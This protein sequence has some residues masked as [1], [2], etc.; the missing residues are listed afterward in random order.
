M[1]L[2]GKLKDQLPTQYRP[3]LKGFETL[4][5]GNLRV[6]I[7]K[8]T[9]YRPVLKG[10]ETQGLASISVVGHWLRSTAPF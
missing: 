5:E 10:F 8:T 6:L 2:T 9:Q 3:V 4:A 7:P 1:S